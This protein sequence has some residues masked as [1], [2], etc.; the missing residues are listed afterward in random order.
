MNHSENS[1]ELQQQIINLEFKVAHQ[2]K[3]I[4]ELNQALY[5]QQKRLDAF[6]KE[7]FDFK[8]NLQSGDPEIRGNERPP[9]Y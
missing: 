7:L 2:E 4:D 6:E 8:K 5:D 9:H 1:S 3:T